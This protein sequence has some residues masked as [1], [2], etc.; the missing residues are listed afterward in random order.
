ML[1]DPLPIEPDE[2]LRL[3]REMDRRYR[4]AVD[5]AHSLERQA[6]QANASA[7]Q[8][9]AAAEGVIRR[10]DELFV[11]RREAQKALRE[12]EP[13]YDP[14]AASA[15]SAISPNSPSQSSIERPSQ[16]QQRER[17]ES[18]A[19][20][21]SYDGVSDGRESEGDL[22]AS[23]GPNGLNG[24]SGDDGVVF[25]SPGRSPGGSSG[26]EA[27]SSPSHLKRGK[28]KRRR[29]RVP[30]T[31][32][33]LIAKQAD[34]VK[35]LKAVEADRAYRTSTSVSMILLKVKPLYKPD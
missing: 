35:R 10:C 3:A 21:S 13:A 15:S 5:L 23:N 11:I 4:A 12:L 27:A 2:A 17:S 28:R 32:T 24:P 8:A 14:E 29:K 26:S 31:L 33:N 30:S 34:M 25:G 22:H 20:A 19:S 18:N 9:A 1:D 7:V 16:G 6:A